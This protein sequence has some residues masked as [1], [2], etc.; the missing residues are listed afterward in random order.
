[1]DLRVKRTINSIKAAFF[2]LRKKKSLD[3]ISVKEL[4]ELAMINK[5]TFYLH[6]RDIY[7]LSDKLETEIINK[8]IDEVKGIS[9][10]DK[11]DFRRFSEAISNAILKNSNEIK[12]LFS[13]FENN[14][15]IN[16]LEDSLKKYLF[17][18][19][20]RIHNTTENNL[21]LTFLVQGS[22]HTYIRNTTVRTDVLV[23]RT[24]DMMTTL[25]EAYTF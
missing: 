14:H 16:H 21:L 20:P 4:S 1:M 8:I 25:A 7:E 13:G 9:F 2:E 18:T 10:T 3:K 12:T 15:F 22:F 17:S 24:T 19:H 23:A 11:N 6:Y 5:A